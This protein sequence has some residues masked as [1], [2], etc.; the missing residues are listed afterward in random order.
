MT[1]ARQGRGSRLDDAAFR[2]LIDDLKA[3]INLSD[4]IGRK[5]PL[6]RA[7]HEHKALCPVHT[8]KTA[9][10]TV[11]DAR[12]WFHC[13]GC[14]FHGD[15]LDW[16]TKIEGLSFR[17][18]YYR[19][20][21]DDLPKISVEERAA[22]RVAL[23]EAD[24]LAEAEAR[25]FWAEAEQVRRG[26]PGDRYLRARGITMT[27]PE[28]IRFGMVP[29]WQHPETKK[30][31]RK[32]P[33][34]IFPTQDRDGIVVGIQRVFVDGERVDKAAAKLSLGT[35]RTAACRLG[36]P[37]AVVATAEGPEDGLSVAQERPG[38]SVWIGFGTAN[39]P[40]IQFPPVVRR[41]IICGQNNPA[42]RLAVENSALAL[43]EQGYEAE[44]RFP[45]ERYDDWNDQL[46]GLER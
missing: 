18:A 12:G 6:K 30:W 22:Q 20:A 27:L 3:Q 19:L 15:V 44:R 1:A 42:G 32:R 36:P 29:A 37:A 25:G 46:R 39:L 7:G 21:N 11:V 13:F 5:L 16:L 31:G 23:K 41:I 45:A 34:L 9:S 14:G 8:E 33:A 43:V 35:I 26:D 17:E 24:L 4:V 2:R 28:T 40:F 10:F 38:L